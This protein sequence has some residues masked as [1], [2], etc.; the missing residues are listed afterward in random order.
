MIL[1]FWVYPYEK[2]FL[3]KETRQKFAKVGAPYQPKCPPPWIQRVRSPLSPEE[4]AEIKANREKDYACQSLLS[5]LTIQKLKLEDRL[6]DPPTTI[7]LADRISASVPNIHIAP[8]IPNTLHF[9]KSKILLCIEEFQP[10][11]L[12]TVIQL[13][14]VFKILDRKDS[15]EDLGLAVKVSP[16]IRDSIWEWFLRLQDLNTD[17]DTIGHKLTNAQWRG[18][19]GALKKI[20]KVSFDNLKNR[21]PEICSDLA[22]LNITLP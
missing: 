16:E 15:N 21:L 11:L 14:P 17:L 1:L 13:E 10:L 6:S 4:W 9:H 8:P 5:R 3:H 7:P 18:L 12:S 20:G 2:I 19:K 22:Q